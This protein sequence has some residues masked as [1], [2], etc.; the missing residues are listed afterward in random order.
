M[1]QVLNVRVLRRLP[2][3]NKQFY[4]NYRV[5]REEGMSVMDVLKYIQDH[6]DAT[7]TFYC[8]CKVGLCLACTVKV[9]GRNVLA[10][11]TAVKENDLLIEPPKDK[12]IRD[13][14]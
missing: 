4:Q 2:E 11:A 3:E 5:P 12:T 6:I 10:C 8:S 13:L 1:T 7:L 9:N 14:I